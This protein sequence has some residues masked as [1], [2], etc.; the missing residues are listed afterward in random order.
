MH[1][2]L[3]DHTLSDLLLS[4]HTLLRDLPA[5]FHSYFTVKHGLPVPDHGLIAHLDNPLMIIPLSDD[6]VI[7]AVRAQWNP[8][9][10]NLCSLSGLWLILTQYDQRGRNNQDSQQ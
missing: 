1:T 10:H 3:M 4:E 5:S 2:A 7:P 6:G 8:L 9:L